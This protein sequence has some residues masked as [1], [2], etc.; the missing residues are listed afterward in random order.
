MSKLMMTS[1]TLGEILLICFV[2]SPGAGLMISPSSST[3]A[4]Q[5]PPI[6][7]SSTAAATSTS[8]YPVLPTLSP[9]PPHACMS[10]PDFKRTSGEVVVT[11]RIYLDISEPVNCS[12]VI[13]SWTYCHFVIGFRDKSSGLWPCIW[14]RSN[15]SSGYENIGCNKFT[16]VPGDGSDI[17]CH[18]YVPSNPSDFIRV[19]EG[20]YIGFYVPD[21]GLF[22]ALSE[23]KYDE[24]HYQ[25]E[26]NETGF[27]TFIGDSELRNT[28]ST[29]GRALLRAEIGQ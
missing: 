1:C 15:D 21:S 12:G 26:R 18:D 20:D 14:R 16:I 10:G 4:T 3:Q 13:T 23:Y 17:R 9:Q 8:N 2:V 24:G 7:S 28:S 19:E 5:S 11:D 22:I 27:S 29:S 25:S 6:S